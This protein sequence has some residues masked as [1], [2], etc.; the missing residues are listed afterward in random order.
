MKKIHKIIIIALLLSSSLVITNFVRANKDVKDSEKF[1][2]EYEALNKNDDSI[3]MNIPSDNPMIYSN[4]TEI[5]DVIKNK[6]GII[7]FGF[8]E[9]PWCRNAVPVLLDSAKQNNVK[10]I[11]YLNPKEYR[12]QNNN[13]YQ[14]L[15][16]ILSSHLNEDEDGNKK[17]YVPDVYFVK[18]GKILGNNLGTVDSQEDPY[19][20]LSET[21][22]SELDNIY[23][24]LINKIK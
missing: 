19:I 23:T 7:Y 13:Q 11:Y 1:K 10:K 12:G 6:S 14:E 2:K 20:A 24:E 15:V 4:L 22:K 17:L 18:N 5:L 8:P 3:Q 9:C 21:Q 16:D